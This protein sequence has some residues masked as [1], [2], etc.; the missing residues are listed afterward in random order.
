[1]IS[2]GVLSV[3]IR[4]RTSA[5]VDRSGRSRRNRLALR[6]ASG[7]RVASRAADRTTPHGGADAIST[8][9]DARPPSRNFCTTKPP[10]EWPTTIGGSAHSATA[11]RTSAT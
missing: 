10:M 11:L 7:W 9:P 8:P 5:E 3:N 6:K 4:S 2:A 1:M